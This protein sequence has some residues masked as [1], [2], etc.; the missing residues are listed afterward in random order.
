MSYI[1][2]REKLPLLPP[3]RNDRRA[4][5]FA[6]FMRDQHRTYVEYIET[7]GLGKDRASEEI[8]ANAESLHQ[9]V[10]AVQGKT[11]PQSIKRC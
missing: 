1:L 6:E 7:G 8:L 11:R 3:P 10:N 5:T 4:P 9:R 2:R